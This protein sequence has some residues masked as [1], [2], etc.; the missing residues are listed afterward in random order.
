M[1]TT[2]VTRE[3]P[4]PAPVTKGRQAVARTWATRSVGP[5]LAA[6][7]STVAAAQAMQ[8]WNWRPGTPL[9]LEGDSA[10]LLVQVRT[11]MDGSP[12]QSTDLVGA[13]FSLNGAWFA[14]AD[15]L[16]FAMIRLLGTL[17]DNPSTAAVIFFVAGFPA[18]A[19]TSYSGGHGSTGSGS[20]RNLEHG[21]SRGR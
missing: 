21:W 9:S 13:P 8:L 18:A 16:N 7:L 14:T 15:Q 5:V 10:Q 19:R 4:A 6:F 2:Q 12:H 3:S 11:I 17:T 20:D 1:S